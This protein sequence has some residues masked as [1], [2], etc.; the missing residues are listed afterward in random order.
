MQDQDAWTDPS[1][2]TGKKT[3]SHG[4]PSMAAFFAFKRLRS[5]A[6]ISCSLVAVRTRVILA[7]TE[8]FCR[9]NSR[10]VE[11]LASPMLFHRTSLL[12]CKANQR[13]GFRP[14]RTTPDITFLVERAMNE[15]ISFCSD[16]LSHC[17]E[18]NN[19]KPHRAGE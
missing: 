5:W 19:A 12:F 6:R 15:R 8:P 13:P 9:R 3:G 14:S 11:G 17:L 10:Q 4:G 2:V 16:R 18:I 1:L 7:W